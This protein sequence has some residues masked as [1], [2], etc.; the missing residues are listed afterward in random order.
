MHS[1]I[2]GRVITSRETRGANISEELLRTV[3]VY[4][5]IYLISERGN[6]VSD[7]DVGRLTLSQFISPATAGEMNRRFGL[8]PFN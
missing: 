7:E 3:S 2:A 5:E 1:D 4:R 6:R 8:F